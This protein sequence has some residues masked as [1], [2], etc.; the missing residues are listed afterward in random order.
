MAV[1]RKHSRTK[2]R[3]HEKGM[4]DQFRAQTGHYTNLTGV[5]RLGFPVSHLMIPSREAQCGRS[6]GCAVEGPSKGLPLYFPN[7]HG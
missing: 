1:S 5:L 6:G 7:P 2:G 3:G 4:E